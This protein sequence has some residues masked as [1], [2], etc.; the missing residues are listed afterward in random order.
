[1]SIRLHAFTCGWLT[2]GL[3]NFL[4]GE[5]GR[6]RVPVPCYLVVHPRGTALFDTGL[7]AGMQHDPAGRLGSLAPAWTVEFAPG[8]EVAGRLAEVELPPA[9][10]DF[11]VTSHLHFDHAGGIAQIPNAKLVVQ[12]AEWQAGRDPDLVRAN[13]YD[14]RD[15]D[16]GHDVLEIRGEHDLF[17]DGSVL[18]IPTPGHT[19][20]H[21]SLRVRLP[22]GDIVLTAD[23]CYLR[24]SLDRLELPPFAHDRAQMRASLQRLRTLEQGGARL[25]FG[26]D[27][28]QW[29]RV[30]QAPRE[31]Q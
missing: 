1:M 31:I 8:E 2:G 18:C 26:H 28:E 16:L 25:F 24:R 27:P 7:H 20:G 29:E 5:H 10:V 22:K 11:I 30:P 6:I 9:R 23:A 4:A 15:Y 19:P 17:G 13:F 12:Q 14:P 3:G 21:Q